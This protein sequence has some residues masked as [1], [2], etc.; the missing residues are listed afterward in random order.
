MGKRPYVKVTSKLFLAQALLNLCPQQYYYY[1]YYY[2]Y[3]SQADL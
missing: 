3:Y 2:Y 1:Y